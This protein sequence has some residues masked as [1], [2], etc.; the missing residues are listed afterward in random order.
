MIKVIIGYKV[1]PGKN[2]QP[3]L[4]SLRANA[5]QFPGYIGSENLI[6]DQDST[7]IAMI[8]TWQH[9]EN[10]RAWEKSRVRTELIQKIRPFLQEEPQVTTYQIMPTIEWGKFPPV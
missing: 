7:I 1:K 6:S 4:M 10:W 8:K 3:M 9:V 2:I 5:M